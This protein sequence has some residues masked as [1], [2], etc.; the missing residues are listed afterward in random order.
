VSI[1]MPAQAALMTTPTMTTVGPIAAGMGGAAADML[2]RRLEGDLSAVAQV[3][4]DGVLEV[5]ES[6][7][8][9]PRL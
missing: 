2:I 7:G 5:R 9:A 6:S 1:D 8:P 3:L 4:F